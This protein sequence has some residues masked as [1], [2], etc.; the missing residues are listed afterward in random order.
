MSSAGTA[1]IRPSPQKINTACVLLAPAPTGPRPAQV[2]AAPRGPR[3][4]LPPPPGRA[5]KRRGVYSAYVPSPQPTNVLRR[6]A[7]ERNRVKQVNHGFTAL[8]NHIPGAAKNKKLSKV[9]TL[10]RA[11]EYIQ[12]LQQQLEEHSEARLSP[13]SY[14]PETHHSGGYLPPAEKTTVPTVGYLTPPGYLPPHEDQ[15]GGYLTPQSS[16][17]PCQASPLILTPS[18]LVS[19]D[20]GVSEPLGYPAGPACPDTPS[21]AAAATRPADYDPAAS[22]PADY[23]P[24]AATHPADYDPAATHPADYD[25][26]ATHAADYAYSEELGCPEPDTEFSAED[27][28]LLDAISWWQTSQ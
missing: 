27:E 26:A 16:P 14:Q 11:M 4:P 17:L 15:P 18:S 3:R 21:P 5:L 13:P 2:T 1:P 20:S 9:D 6:N 10:R 23:D 22:H 8:R 7:R 24:A 28:E 12:S 19:V 25:P